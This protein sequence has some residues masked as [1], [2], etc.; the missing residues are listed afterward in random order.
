MAGLVYTSEIFG[1]AAVILVTT[2]G[3]LPVAGEV[4]Q[5]A[6]V[7]GETSLFSSSYPVICVWETEQW[8][9][10]SARCTYL[11]LGAAEFGG[12]VWVG[13]GASLNTSSK[14]EIIDTTYNESWIWNST[15]NIFV[16]SYLGLTTIGNQEKI[17]GD[18]A[19]P[20]GWSFTTNTGGSVVTSGGKLVFTATSSSA[21]GGTSSNNRIFFRYQLSN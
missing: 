6:L 3:D 12:G 5:R 17:K 15:S 8:K 21:G 13:T 16:P 7:T 14:C 2:F 19:T 9:L 10:E 4:D 18:S 1:G 11:N 20:A